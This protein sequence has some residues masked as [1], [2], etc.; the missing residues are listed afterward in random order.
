MDGS[1]RTAVVRPSPDNVGGADWEVAA[2]A[3]FD[4]DKSTDILWQR[5]QTNEL[6]VWFMDGAV[7]TGVASPYPD[8]PSSDVADWKIAASGDYDGDQQTDLLWQHRTEGYLV[9]WIMNGIVK[10]ETRFPVPNQPSA[11]FANWKVML[12]DALAPRTAP[13][14]WLWQ[15]LLDGWL[16]VWNMNGVVKVSSVFPSPNRPD[17]DP[18]DWKLVGSGDFSGDGAVDLVFRN[19][20]L[21]A[22]SVWIMNGTTRTGTVALPA[23]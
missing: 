4:G 6:V 18:G 10:S 19:R 17:T 20:K 22:T 16:V 9:A 21:G 11:D 14:Q 8:R 3:D 23:H 12:A 5:R 1:N 2:A 7:R 15:H 13:Q